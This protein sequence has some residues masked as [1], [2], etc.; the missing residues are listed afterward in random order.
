MVFPRR[1]ALVLGTAAAILMLGTVV[2]VGILRRAA[3]ER[4]VEHTYDVMR[5]ADRAFTGLVSAETGQRGYILTGL[6]AYLEPYHAGLRTYDSC[7]RGAA[8]AHPRQSRTAASARYPRE[9][10]VEAASRARQ[11]AADSPHEGLRGGHDPAPDESGQ[12]HDGFGSAGG[13]GY[14]ARGNG[15]AGGAAGRRDPSRPAGLPVD[16]LGDRRRRG[17]SSWCRADCCRGPWVPRRS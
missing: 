5:A 9:L 4:L 17:D 15:A 11:H 16:G 2:A 12:G 7:G 6:D 13:G 8:P 3:A 10:G 1:R 14:R